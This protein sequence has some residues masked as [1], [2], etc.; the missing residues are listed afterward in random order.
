MTGFPAHYQ[1]A[2]FNPQH[3]QAAGQLIDVLPGSSIGSQ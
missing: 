3:Q 1:S 2:S